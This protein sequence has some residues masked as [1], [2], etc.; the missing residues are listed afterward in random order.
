M[1]QI[2]FIYLLSVS[3]TSNVR[4]V[5]TLVRNASIIISYYHILYVQLISC[6]ITAIC[7]VSA[8]STCGGN[9]FRNVRE[10]RS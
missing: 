3:E 4:A 8:I 7:L 9:R 5:E 1:L 10:E 6:F 2:R